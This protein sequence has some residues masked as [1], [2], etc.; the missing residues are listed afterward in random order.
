MRKITLFE[1]S[2]KK[3][4]NIAQILFLL[5]I[6]ASI[7]GIAVLSLATESFAWLLL[8]PVAILIAY[9]T[10][11]FLYGFGEIVDNNIHTNKKTA[12]TEGKFDSLPEL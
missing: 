4:K 12:A 8:I 2:G 10:N 6:I 11:I 5:E 3:I 1:N 7:I 9:T